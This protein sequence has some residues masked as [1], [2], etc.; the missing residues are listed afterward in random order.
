M[1]QTFSCSAGTAASL[2]GESPTRRSVVWSV[3]C[4]P[5]DRGLADLSRI[6]L[7]W[8]GGPHARLGLEVALRIADATGARVDL[9]RAVR[10]DVDPDREIASVRDEIEPLTADVETPVEVLVRPSGD[11]VA[12]IVETARENPYDLLIIGASGESGIRT[13][14]FG[15]IPD[16]VADRAPCSVLLVRRYVPEH[17]AYRTSERFKRLRERAGFTSSAE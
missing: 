14:L 1:G 15:T 9:L 3:A 13:V 8:G 4:R 17:W 2:S 11:V 7:P 12:T 5:N 6:L 16:I 10:P